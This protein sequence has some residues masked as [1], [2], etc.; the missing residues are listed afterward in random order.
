MTPDTSTRLSSPWSQTIRKVEGRSPTVTLV[1]RGKR[2]YG[3]ALSSLIQV[4]PAA[5]ED[6]TVRPCPGHRFGDLGGTRFPSD[7]LAV[8]DADQNLEIRPHDMEVRR[9][10]IPR[11]HTQFR[12]PKDL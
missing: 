6:L 4:S 9:P 11:I 2:L 5:H 12:S 1:I 10:M 8:D 3:I 7:H